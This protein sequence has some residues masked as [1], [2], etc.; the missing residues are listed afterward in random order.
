MLVCPTVNSGEK[1]RLQLQNFVLTR[2]PM[3][4]VPKSYSLPLQSVPNPLIDPRKDWLPFYEDDYSY[5]LNTLGNVFILY[6]REVEW[7][8]K[9][10]PVPYIIQTI[11]LILVK[12]SFIHLILVNLK[13]IS[14][15]AYSKCSRNK[16]HI[17][18][19]L[20]AYQWNIAEKTSSVH[21]YM[22][23]FRFYP[24]TAG[25]ISIYNIVWSCIQNV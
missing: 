24:S 4:S 18:L 22:K 7:Y 12:K 16:I 3:V 21:P 15:N 5:A 13:H 25:E 2:R 23:P 20:L 10:T 6:P 14:Y 1:E 8:C 11:H 19:L 17:L 9:S